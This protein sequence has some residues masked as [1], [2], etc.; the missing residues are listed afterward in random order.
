VSDA[1]YYAQGRERVGP[2]D[3]QAL[4]AALA[5]NHDW[6]NVLVWRPG[7]AEWTRAGEIAELAIAG[8]AVPSAPFGQ[9]ALAGAPAPTAE[10]GVPPSVLHVWFGFSGRLNRAK[11]WLVGLINCA[12]IVAGAIFA[13][14]TDSN[15]AWAG[16]ALVYLALAISGLAITIKRL[17]DRDKSGWWALLFL[18]APSVISGIGAASGQIGGAVT[19]LVSFGISIWAL[20]ELGCLR[21]TVGPNQFGP[22]PLAGKPSQLTS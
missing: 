15:I 13:Y 18:V 11:L 12:I 19:G 21:G 8:G 10:A 1:W 3:V 20:V 22:D 9:P 4:K 16:F 14:L 6:K 5:G 2:I 7:F 17:H